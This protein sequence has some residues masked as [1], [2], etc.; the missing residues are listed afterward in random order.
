MEHC[1][2]LQDLGTSSGEIDDQAMS[3]TSSMMDGI[4]SVILDVEETLMD[5]HNT[6]EDTSEPSPEEITDQT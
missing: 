4:H 2:K 1:N 5:G 6:F 3:I